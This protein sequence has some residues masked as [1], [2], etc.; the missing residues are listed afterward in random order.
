MITGRSASRSSATARSSASPSGSGPAAGSGSGARRA[1]APRPPRRRGRAGS[2]G[3]SG[4]SAA[5]PRRPA[6]RRPAPG[7]RPSTSAVAASFVS[8]ADERH[9]VDLLQRA[10]AP[11]QRGR[12]AA[13]D[14]HRRVVL[15]RATRAR[16]S[17]FVTPG[18]GG[19]RRDPG[20]ARDLRPA[21]GGERGRRLVAH[22]DEVDALRPAAVVDREEVPAREREQLRDAVRLQP[23]R[24]QPPAVQRRRGSVPVS[25]LIGR[26][27]VPAVI[28]AAPWRAR[29]RPPGRRRRRAPRAART[30]APARSCP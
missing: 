15:L 27:L 1:R 12:A 4:P 14:E 25:V 10:L 9:V 19:E 16:S 13:E 30:G 8:G 7:S 26:R 29:L 24:D 5:S 21:L 18:P 3:T 2:R 17:P 20:P 23:P 22:V 11:A 6:P 28:A